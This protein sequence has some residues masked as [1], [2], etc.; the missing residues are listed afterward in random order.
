MKKPA[1]LIF[2]ALVFLLQLI[3]SDYLHLGPWISICLIPF[4]ILHISLS[5]SPHAVMLIAFALGLGLD[6]L[7]DGVPGLNAFAAV[8]AAAP[9][10]LFYRFFVNSDRQDK[11]EVPLLKEIGF[12]KYLKYLVSVTAVYTAA[13]TLLD[14]VSFRPVQ[15]IFVKFAASTL[16]STLVSLLLAA[17]VQN[18]RS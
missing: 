8:T 6:V 14:C 3:V 7:S 17:A 10:K 18:N 16:V 13:Y 2:F 11:T 1:D 9:R 12:V 4:L 15:F 5:R